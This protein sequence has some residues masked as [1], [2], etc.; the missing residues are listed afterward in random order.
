MMKLDALASPSERVT[1]TLANASYV[2]QSHDLTS[3]R[4]MAPGTFGRAYATFLDA[5]GITP[6]EVTEATRA[7]FRDRPYAL[8]YTATHDLHHVL[9]GFDAGL[10]GELGVFAFNVAQGSAPGGRGMLVLARVLYS[11]LAPTQAATIAHD[12]HVG[13]RLGERA[14]L[15][16]AAPLESWFA[17][18]LGDV[19]RKLGIDD[20]AL[21]GVHPSGPSL[22]GKLLAMP[23]HATTG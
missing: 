4:R 2:W 12:M 5:N 10:A 19:R 7:R 1:A 13:L 15:V 9:T 11:I 22:V 14:E 21:V 6:L 18:P 16:I 8:R 23:K 17:E 3:L 20:P